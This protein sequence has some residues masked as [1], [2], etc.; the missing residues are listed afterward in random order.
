MSET[1]VTTADGATPAEP[2]ALLTEIAALRAAAQQFTTATAQ[3][4]ALAER[5]EEIITRLH[6][7]LQRSRRGELDAALDLV[8]NSLIRLHDQII[9]QAAQLKA[10]LGVEELTALLR[11]VADDAADAVAQTGVDRYTPKAGEPYNSAW[12]RPV[13]RVAAETPDAHNTVASSVAA[14]FAQDERIVRKAEVVVALWSPPV[15]AVDPTTPTPPSPE[16]R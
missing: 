13:G 14:G 5:R 9:R 15:G 12:H 11:A 4:H 1:E 2:D 10:P 7:E 8:R 16:A 3:Q 6:D